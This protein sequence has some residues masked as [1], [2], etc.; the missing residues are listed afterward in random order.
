MVKRRGKVW[1]PLV[2]DAT[3]QTLR[4]YQ[5]VS[6]HIT[7]KRHADRKIYGPVQFV[8]FLRVRSL[9]LLKQ[10]ER[11]GNAVDG[12]HQFAGTKFRHWRVRNE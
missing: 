1:Y 11:P 4:I 3:E 8:V 7:D 12:T 10:E 6:L 2:H 5:Y 9:G